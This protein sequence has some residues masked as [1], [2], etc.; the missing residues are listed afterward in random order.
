MNFTQ[1]N[2]IMVKRN[3]IETYSKHNGGKSIFI[4]RFIKTLKNEI[5]KYLIL[6]S[7]NMCIDKLKNIAEKYN[8]KYH[9]TIKVKPIDLKSSTYIDFV[10]ES[11]Q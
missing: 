9:K 2:E 5:Y 11:N 4:E 7:K 1:F 10:V 6:I 8:K 3:D